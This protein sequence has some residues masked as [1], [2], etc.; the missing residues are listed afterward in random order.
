[1]NDSE[2]ITFENAKRFVDY[3]G[4]GESFRV[5]GVYHPKNPG[6]EIISIVAIDAVYSRHFRRSSV[7]RDL[8]KAFAGFSNVPDKNIVSGGWGCGAFGGDLYH[9]FV[10]QVLA[11]A[12]AG[13]E[14]VFSSYHD[15]KV[16]AKLEGMIDLID[17]K[18]SMQVY[19]VLVSYKP[20]S[21]S[22]YEFFV[23][24]IKR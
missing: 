4:F 8:K 19:N 11:A 15:T 5:V 14:L 12:A 3:R 17:G 23:N 24:K 2:A 20:S 13:K 6:K 21:G 1:M 10:I 22:F 9:K 18:S 16:K 7:D